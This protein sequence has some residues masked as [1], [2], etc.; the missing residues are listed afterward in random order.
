MA[1]TCWRTRYT[2]EEAARVLS[3]EISDK[4]GLDDLFTVDDL[5]EQDEEYGD[6]D[7]ESTT[8]RSDFEESTPYTSQVSAS[9]V[10]SG[11]R[12][13]GSVSPSPPPKRSRRSDRLVTCIDAVLEPN[14]FEKMDVSPAT[15]K[16][17][18]GCPGP[19]KK[20]WRRY[21]GQMLSQMPEDA[22]TSVISSGALQDWKVGK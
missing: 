8:D 3:N 22:S 19:R 11:E 9:I 15:R 7:G 13:T 1:A 4:D 2:A 16:I 5:D 6:P 21:C 14:N 12:L 20:I 18:T 17:Y 10:S